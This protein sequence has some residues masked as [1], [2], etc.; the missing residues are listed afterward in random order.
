MRKDIK[1]YVEGCEEC[2]RNKISRKARDQQLVS[3]NIPKGLWQ[4][5]NMDIIGPLP[6]SQG[7]NAILVIMDQFVMA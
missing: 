2:Q 4:V 1:E 7:Y 5:I 6:L 3:H